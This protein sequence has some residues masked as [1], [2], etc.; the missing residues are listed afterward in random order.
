LCSKVSD[1]NAE[2][3]I[4][5]PKFVSTPLSLGALFP[6]IMGDGSPFG[7]VKIAQYQ[8]EERKNGVK[9]VVFPQKD[10]LLWFELAE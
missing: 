3:K 2:E 8:T 9:R 6:S 1:F 4:F 7:G 10:I 5:A